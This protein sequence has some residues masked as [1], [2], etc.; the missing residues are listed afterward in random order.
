[1]R[2]GFTENVYTDLG[3]VTVS[4]TDRD[5]NVVAIPKDD[6]NGWSFDDPQTPSRI[7]LNGS[8]CSAS[9]GAPSGRIDVLIGCRVP[10]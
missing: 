2:V 6:V 4:V 1:M 8:A 3:N 7:I 10:N 9:T 5:G